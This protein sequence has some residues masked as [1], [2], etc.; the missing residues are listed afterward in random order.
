MKAGMSIS[1]MQGHQNSY[2]AGRS[3]GDEVMCVVKGEDVGQVSRGEVGLVTVNPS[4][5][6]RLGVWLLEKAGT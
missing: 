4:P 3:V 1:L 5:D 6:S 2:A